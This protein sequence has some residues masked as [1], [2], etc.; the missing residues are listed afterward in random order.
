MPSIE[1]VDYPE[2][3][4]NR[5]NIN[6]IV[7][8]VLATFVGGGGVSLTQVFNLPDRDELRTLVRE[9]TA[10]AVQ[11]A[12]EDAAEKAAQRVLA[13][14][15]MVETRID[16]RIDELYR[17]VDTMVPYAAAVTPMIKRSSTARREYRK[18]QQDGF[19][20]LEPEEVTQ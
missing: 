12:A 1:S 3:K 19:E 13:R 7:A 20:A 4:P 9:E 2:Y 18:A 10:K 11:A 5:V 8:L 17:R 14:Q 16:S 15:H 6:K